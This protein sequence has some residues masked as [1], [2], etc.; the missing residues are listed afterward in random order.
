MLAGDAARLVLAN[1][2]HWGHPTPDGVFSS[3]AVLGAAL[4]K[5][6]LFPAVKIRK[7]MDCLLL[8]HNY[9]SKSFSAST[10]EQRLCSRKVDNLN[11]ANQ[12]MSENK[13]T[14]LQPR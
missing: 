3:D 1:K 9:F 10:I 6:R 5:R 8:K 4:Q 12:P 2:V 7:I 14:L 11:R 13:S